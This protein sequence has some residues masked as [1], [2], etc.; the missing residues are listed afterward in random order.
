[1]EHV[2]PLAEDFNGI[3]GT[4]ADQRYISALDPSGVALAGLKG[5]LYEVEVLKQRNAELER[6]ISEL[7]QA[8]RY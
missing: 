5:L 1:M 8:G 7:E 4:G 6:R 2:G 3:F